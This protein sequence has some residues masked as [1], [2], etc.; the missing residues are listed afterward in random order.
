MIINSCV[1]Q[2]H[3]QILLYYYNMLGLDFQDKI[4]KNQG[5]CL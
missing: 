1:V 5:A 2:P 3:Q 4:E